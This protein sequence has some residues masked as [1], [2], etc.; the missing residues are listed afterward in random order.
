MHARVFWQGVKSVEFGS[1]RIRAKRLCRQRDV[2]LQRAIATTE[3]CNIAVAATFRFNA[4]S[5][6]RH[7][8]WNFDATGYVDSIDCDVDLVDPTRR[9]DPTRS[10]RCVDSTRCDAELV[11]PTWC[12]DPTRWARARN[13]CLKVVAVGQARV[14]AVARGKSSNPCLPSQKT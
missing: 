2:M 3:T 6:S 14:I 10:T 1:R 8:P 9:L 13:R 11:D 5:N 7:S 12:I 4:A